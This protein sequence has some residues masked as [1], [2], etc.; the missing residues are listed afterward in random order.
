MLLYYECG[1]SEDEIKIYEFK[2]TLCPYSAPTRSR[3]DRHEAKHVPDGVKRRRCAECPYVSKF[4]CD[5]RSHQEMHNMRG[6]FR[7]S[8]C[9]YSTKRAISLRT[10]LA[11]HAEEN[12]KRVR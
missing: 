11:L 6:R 1:F 9:S 12:D 8:Q 3:L 7:C 2:C 10:H 5:M 4:S